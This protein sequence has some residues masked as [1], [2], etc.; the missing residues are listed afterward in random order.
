MKESEVRVQSW[1]WLNAA[2][3]WLLPF[4]DEEHSLTRI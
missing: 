2:A 4:L 3:D 1:M